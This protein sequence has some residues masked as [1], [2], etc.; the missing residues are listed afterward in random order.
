MMV[1][2]K[3]TKNNEKVQRSTIRF[4]V[5]LDPEQHQFLKLFSIEN[6]I[7]ASVIMRALIYQLEVN[8]ELANRV[9]DEI[10]SE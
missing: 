8:E 6:G 9:I 3:A 10:F 2:A 1:K 7:Q 4:S 5:D